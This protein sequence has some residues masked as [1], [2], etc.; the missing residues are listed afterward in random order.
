MKRKGLFI[1]GLLAM[2]TVAGCAT[3]VQETV[4][5]EAGITLGVK[6]DDKATAE[7]ETGTGDKATPEGEVT[8]VPEPT[9]VA[10]ISK[11]KELADHIKNAHEDELSASLVEQG[12]YYEV[13][14]SATD[15]IFQV[16]FKAV[17][18]DMNTPML[19]F[20]VD[21]NDAELTGKYEN[22]KLYAHILSEDIYDNN[23]GTYLPWE[24]YGKQDATHK[25]RYHVMMPGAGI[26]MATG[27]SF[28]VDVC[29]VDFV[30][31][32]GQAQEYPLNVPETRLTIPQQKFYPVM[33]LGYTN[34]SFTHSGREYLLTEAEYGQYSTKLSFACHA[35]KDKTY[36][37]SGEIEQFNENFRLIWQDFLANVSLEVD[38]KTYYISDSGMMSFSEEGGTEKTYRG[39]GWADMPGVNYPK[40]KEAILWVGTTGY[41]LKNKDKAPLTR[42]LPATPDVEMTPE[43]KELAEHLRSKC[44][45]EVSAELVEQGYYYLVNESRNYENFRF[46]F[47]ALTGDE[48][49]LK[50]VFDVCVEDAVLPEMYPVLRLDV[51]CLREENYDPQDEYGWNCIGY[52]IQDAENKQCYHVVMDAFLF[53]YCPVVTDIYRVGFDVDTNETNGQLIY[54]VNPEPYYLEVSSEVF[55]PVLAGY[56]SGMTFTEGEKEYE[57]YSIS[58]ENYKTDVGFCTFIDATEVPKDDTELWEYRDEI[59]KNWLALSSKLTLVVDGTEYNVIDEEG[60]RGYVW[61]DVI[62]G[63]TSYRGNVH[64]YFPA[65]DYLGAS[66]IQLKAG[67]TIYRLK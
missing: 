32:S 1:F 39:K 46:D 40:A 57:L 11:Q 9:P 33:E 14:K 18:G 42:E 31:K 54:N 15:G 22:I 7:E 37:F 26:W 56:Y 52:G 53:G 49:N 36:T 43:Q 34:I 67:D 28:V 44:K 38:G 29:Q 21:V 47:K 59:Q 61:F 17:T 19:V 58:Y 2:L 45:D 50:M 55:A 3:K 66:D 48:G 6:E 41:D 62:E 64:P 25:N 10:V 65:I 5:N 4:G 35:D 63:K 12:Y 20:D 60:M 51:G 8:K 13:N 24:G 23:S 27:D 16:E 30:S